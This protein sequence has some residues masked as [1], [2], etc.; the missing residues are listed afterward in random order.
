I[1]KTIG[2]E[3]RG[4]PRLDARL[5][6]RVGLVRE[7]EIRLAAETP[8]SARAVGNERETQASLLPARDLHAAGE[9]RVAGLERLRAGWAE[10]RGSLDVGWDSDGLDLVDDAVGD[11]QPLGQIGQVHHS[12]DGVIDAELE[13]VVPRGAGPD[14][15]RTARRTGYQRTVAETEPAKVTR[16]DPYAALEKNAVEDE[17]PTRHASRT[18]GALDLEVAQQMLAPA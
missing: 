18:V 2:G 4:Q 12:T 15:H 6:V 1:P 11:V 13:P 5:L 7:G 17:R 3:D 9:D 8:G 14:T 16:E 10:H